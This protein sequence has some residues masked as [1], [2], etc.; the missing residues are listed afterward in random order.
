MYV[1]AVVH[2][3]TLRRWR[4]GEQVLPVHATTG[5]SAAHATYRAAGGNRPEPCDVITWTF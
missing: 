5:P 4:R 1:F 3:P 2:P